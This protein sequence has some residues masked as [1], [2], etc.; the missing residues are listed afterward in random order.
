MNTFH[1]N[2]AENDEINNKQNEQ[3]GWIEQGEANKQIDLD[4]N[5]N[6]NNKLNENSSLKKEDQGDTS[7]EITDVYYEVSFEYKGKVIIQK[8][9]SGEKATEVEFPSLKG[10]T[11]CWVDENDNKFDFNSTIT[12]NIKLTAI[13]MPE[14]HGEKEY[15]LYFYKEKS[16]KTGIKMHIKGSNTYLTLPVV[17]KAGYDFI[18]WYDENGRLWKNGRGNPEETSFLYA[19]WQKIQPVQTNY[20]VSPKT[21]DENNVM[22]YTLMLFMGVVVFGIIKNKNKGY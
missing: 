19:H 1:V 16:D 2:A 5:K 18:G 21:A 17:K 11:Y 3:V 13:V 12:A 7:E 14:M 20:N 22:L 6:D 8:V 10:K 9:K 4:N 15:D